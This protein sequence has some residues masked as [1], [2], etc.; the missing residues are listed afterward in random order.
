M[1][2]SACYMRVRA[3][4]SV[5]DSQSYRGSEKKKVRR[6]NGEMAGCVSILTLEG[7][8]INSNVAL[9]NPTHA[10]GPRFDRYR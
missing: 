8:K 2:E 4:A 5:V 6:K 1:L 10:H 7:I 9:Q 3:Q